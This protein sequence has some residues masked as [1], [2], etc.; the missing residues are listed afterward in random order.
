L[1]KEER[2]M[3]AIGFFLAF[4][5]GVLMSPWGDVDIPRESHR[6][7][8]PGYTYRT[9]LPMQCREWRPPRPTPTS[10]PTPTPIRTPTPTRT[11]TPTHT[12]T[13]TPTPRPNP[14]PPNGTNLMCRLYGP[15]QICAWVSDGHPEQNSNVTVLGRLYV[16]GFPAVGA[17]MHTVWY[18]RTT[19]NTQDCLTDAEGIGRCTRNIGRAT[20]NYIVWVDVLIR[21]QDVEYG[22][23]TFFTPR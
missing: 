15:A 17:P 22:T 4:L 19:T 18:Y 12:P 20:P 2:M 23:R 8:G 1:R 6:F 14:T 3:N 21:Y 11:A 16:A 9:Y 5:V 10:T 13:P 7:G